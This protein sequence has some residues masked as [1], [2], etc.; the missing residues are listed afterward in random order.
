MSN[1]P[2]CLPPYPHAL[3]LILMCEGHVPVPV[4]P[5][6]VMNLLATQGTTIYLRPYRHYPPIQHTL[7][8]TYLETHRINQQE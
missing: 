8:T 5:S 1:V 4:S 3:I 7:R 2:Y 6:P